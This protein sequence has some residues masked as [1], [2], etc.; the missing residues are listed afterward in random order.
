MLTGRLPFAGPV[1]AVLG[2]I[3]AVEPDPPSKHRPD[4]DPALEA[5]CLK[6]MAKRVA[7]RHASMADLAADLSDYLRPASD[8]PRSTIVEAPAP[9]AT[10]SSPRRP[11]PTM[12]E[13]PPRRSRGKFWV[14]GGLALVVLAAAVTLAVVRVR[15][16]IGTVVL[17]VAE[18]G[19]EVA[20][21]GQRI[22]VADPNT[23]EPILIEVEEGRHELTVTKGGFKTYTSAFDVTRGDRTVL[24]VRLVRDGPEKKAEI[25]QKLVK[26]DRKSGNRN[27][28]DP[29]GFKPPPPPPE[30]NPAPPPQSPAPPKGLPRD[31]WIT[32]DEN[33]PNTAS[34]VWDKPKRK[35]EQLKW[36]AGALTL[37]NRGYAFNSIQARDLSFRAQV[38]F[39]E[40][41]NMALIVR[42]KRGGGGIYVMFHPFKD[43][44]A[45][46]ILNRVDHKFINRPA[47]FFELRVTAIGSQ[48][49]VQANGQTLIEHTLKEPP[50]VGHVELTAYDARG[51]FKDIEVRILD[52]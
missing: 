4:L 27:E 33:T 31:R 21:D 45:I 39:I 30:K 13:S 41:N 10:G 23:K 52:K 34:W 15:T 28:P 16:R 49:T 6:A 50:E 18:P 36:D 51:V 7:D 19:A 38:K 3:L 24:S 22:T 37:E 47:D 5:I 17:D 48:V 12:I 32:L 14:A 2:Q 35:T 20:I 11:Q 43:Q 29:V 40:G 44:M 46:A 1:T 25:E 8:G 9:T 42:N 26:N